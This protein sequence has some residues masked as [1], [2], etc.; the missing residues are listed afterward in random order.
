[1]GDSTLN[2]IIEI[3]ILIASGVGILGLLVAKK[4]GYDLYELVHNIKLI[5]RDKDA[6]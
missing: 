1:M 6:E 2:T 5:K 4:M 3:G